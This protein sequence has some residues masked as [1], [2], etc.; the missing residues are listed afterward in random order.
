LFGAALLAAVHDKVTDPEVVRALQARVFQAYGRHIV[1][2]AYPVG[3][4]K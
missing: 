2:S 1:E 4:S 3:A